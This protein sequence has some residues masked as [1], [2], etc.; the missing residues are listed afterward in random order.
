MSI[1]GRKNKNFVKEG[2]GAGVLIT[3]EDLVGQFDYYKVD[4]KD[5]VVDVYLKNVSLEDCAIHTYYWSTEKWD[6]DGGKAILTYDWSDFTDQEKKEF[7]EDLKNSHGLGTGACTLTHGG[8]YLHASLDGM[9]TCNV[10]GGIHH[11]WLHLHSSLRDESWDVNITEIKLDFGNKLEE[12]YQDGEDRYLHYDDE[13]YS[14]EQEAIDSEKWMNEKRIRNIIRQMKMKVEKISPQKIKD[15]SQTY[16]FIWWDLDGTDYS[17]YSNG[18]SLIASTDKALKDAVSKEK[19]P[20]P[21]QKNVSKE[22]ET[23]IKKVS[24][25][26]AGNWIDTKLT[27]ADLKNNPDKMKEAGIKLNARNLIDFLRM[28]SGYVTA[29]T[30]V[31]YNHYMDAIGIGYKGELGILMCSN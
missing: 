7:L 27:V 4:S 1:I 25:V 9:I 28:F 26:S 2:A 15:W 14:D 8:G 24:G 20:S 21:Y 29:R 19:D 6:F 17:C 5:D 30:P 23:L 13:Y 18:Y 11:D 16:A 12:F 10:Y 3:M 31:Y 22:V